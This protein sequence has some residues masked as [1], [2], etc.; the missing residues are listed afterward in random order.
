[1]KQKIITFAFAITMATLS[2]PAV[3]AE[4]QPSE[5]E[6]ECRMK[7]AFTFQ[8]KSH[9]CKKKKGAA[10]K[11]CDEANE[12]TLNEAVEKCKEAK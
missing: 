5:K 2:A 9:A 11:K 12:K 3:F 1:M 7:A 10:Q 4:A 6:Q 8:E